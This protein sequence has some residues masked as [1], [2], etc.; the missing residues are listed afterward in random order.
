MKL[1]FALSSRITRSSLGILQ[2]DGAPAWII[3][4]EEC[5]KD[6][7]IDRPEGLGVPAL[8]LVVGGRG[9]A[10]TRRAA[11]CAG[12]RGIL[13]IPPGGSDP[14]SQ[15]CAGTIAEIPSVNAWAEAIRVSAP[16]L[17]RV[18][19]KNHHK[20]PYAELT[21]RKLHYAHLPERR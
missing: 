6:Y 2:S 16:H 8:E 4:D 11:P 19:R 18:L 1:P 17:C 5:R 10:G 3:L 21:D 14:L 15:R 13:R 12:A 20:T 7:I 9:G